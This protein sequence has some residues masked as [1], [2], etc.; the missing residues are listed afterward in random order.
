[1]QMNDSGSEGALNSSASKNYWES[2]ELR[3]LEESTQSEGTGSVNQP[4][5]SVNQ[6]HP[7]ADVPSNPNRAG[8]SALPGQD[9]NLSTTVDQPAPEKNPL[10]PLLQEE[11]ERGD[12]L[13]RLHRLV[14]DQLQH[15]CERDLPRW[16]QSQV[17][18]PYDQAAVYIL[19]EDLEIENDTT[20]E[21]RDLIAKLGMDPSLMKGIYQPLKIKRFW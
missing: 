19:K 3:V 11:G 12:L 6:P 9:S 1:M 21:I 16:R 7:D 18:D 2:F 5:A 15:Y 4:E 8:P 10:I 17:T 20:P 13:R 14:S